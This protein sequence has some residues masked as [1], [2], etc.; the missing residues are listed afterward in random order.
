MS[1]LFKR[2]VDDSIQE[3]SVEVE[4]DRYR[5]ISGRRDGA[6]V[7]SKWTVCQGK[8]EGKANATT[9]HEQAVKQAEALARK[10]MDKGY[11]D[12]LIQ[13]DTVNIVKPMLADKYA[14]AKRFKAVEAALKE[15]RAVFVQPKLDGIRSLVNGRCM[16]SRQWKPIVSAPHIRYSVAASSRLGPGQMFD[17]EIYA[18]KLKADFDR[19]I[20]L[21]RKTA[22]TEEDLAESEKNLEYHVYDLIT[23]DD[24]P[25]QKRFELLTELTRGMPYV[26]LVE[27]HRVTSLEQIDQLYMEFLFQ[28]YEGQMI[29]IDGPYEHKRSSLLLKRKEF[30]D[31]EFTISACESGVG[32]REGCLVLVCTTEDRKEF[33]AALKCNVTRM[34]ELYEQRDA[35]VGEQATIRFQALTKDG[36]PRFPVAVA[37]REFL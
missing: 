17:G 29:R 21:A 26:H 8:N 12:S 10:K 14:D 9:S 30:Q 32:N 23:N 5:T 24:M 33:R 2:N 35:L 34:Q 37:I 11:T 36:V 19:I 3:W 16:M 20:S 7:V 25:F 1:T 22:P 4:G 15:G 27:T 31:A 28:G 18:H 6:K 13:V